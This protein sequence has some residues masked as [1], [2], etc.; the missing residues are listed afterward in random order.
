MEIT[1][2]KLDVSLVPRELRKY[3]RA[4]FANGDAGG[5][6]CTMSNELGM[7]FVLTNLEV[8][9][10]RGIYESALVHAYTITRTNHR[11]IALWRLKLMFDFADRSKLQAAGDPIPD[12]E[13]FILY[14]GVVGRGTARRAAGMS[15]TRDLE[16]AKWFANR[17]AFAGN[18]AVYRANVKRAAIYCYSNDR[19]EDDFIVY[20]TK[21]EQAF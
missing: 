17:F 10:A 11:N 3:A 8:L 9:K 19:Q 18:P 21:R 7:L 4:R 13:S 5:V 1:V 14:R 12:G 6:L 16:K 2:A 15:W 20:A